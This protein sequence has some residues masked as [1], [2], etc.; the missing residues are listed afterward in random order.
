MI[1]PIHNLLNQTTR[2]KNA[3]NKNLY[4]SNIA[5]CTR[6]T[7]T[8]PDD[9]HPYTVNDVITPVSTEEL[10]N[11]YPTLKVDTAG[12]AA[13]EG[14]SCINAPTTVQSGVVH[15]A[16]ALVKGPAGA[17]MRFT[18]TGGLTGVD[19]NLTGGWDMLKITGTTTGTS[20]YPHIRTR[21]TQD[22]TFYIALLIVREGTY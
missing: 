3:I 17:Q 4:K 2:R 15:T 7:G 16:Y 11:G 10:W 21:A 13:A 20:F 14:V 6:A 12:L 22:I 18:N 19:Y 8:N 1:M 5:T 9:F